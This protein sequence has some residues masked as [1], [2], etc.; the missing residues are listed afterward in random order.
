MKPASLPV[1]ATLVLL[2]L[3]LTEA[4]SQSSRRYTA[5][6][7]NP[8]S[9]VTNLFV[10]GMNETGSLAATGLNSMKEPIALRRVGTAWQ[11]LGPGF[12]NGINDAGT[13]VG[14]NELGQPV[15]WTGPG[16]ATIIPGLPPGAVP[17][18]INNAGTIIATHNAAA[19]RVSA[20]SEV[21]NLGT[22]GDSISLQVNDINASGAFV[23]IGLSPEGLTRPF[24]FA[25][26]SF[27]G[28]LVS[29]VAASGAPREGVAEAINGSGQVAGFI[30]VGKVSR[31]T[32]WFS[33]TVRTEL[34][35]PEG[36]STRAHGITDSG[37]A[38]GEVSA[39]VPEGSSRACAW[40]EN[41]LV[42]VNQ[43]TKGGALGL[44]NAKAITNT[45]R[46]LAESVVKGEVK[47]FELLPEGTT[48][49]GLPDLTLEFGPRSLKTIGR[50]PRA[51]MQLSGTV[52]VSN[53]GTA[54]TK[55]ITEL[56]V[57]LGPRM[58]EGGTTV[59]A[60]VPKLRA[61]QSRTFRYKY[62][63]GG[64]ST[65]VLAA[66]VNSGREF[67]ELNHSNNEAFVLKLP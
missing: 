32:I 29:E 20:G 57:I 35:T 43:A 11:T 58:G 53:V 1:A 10:S 62:R 65:S 16:A 14:Q 31:A 52:K 3:G 66:F 17:S 2:V 30:V 44:K 45:L 18:V 27:Q 36:H 33:P 23:G 41:T 56:R 39:N 48:P 40:I 46:I 50:G 60:R 54:G 55:K 34:P 51:F 42:D 63:T 19:F 15:F 38:C 5:T 37:V 22:F 6:A 25:D 26:G 59:R 8:P 67:E 61:G 49:G 21:T 7:V 64:L 12:T 47:L 13:V 24:R 9:G 4:R 28:L